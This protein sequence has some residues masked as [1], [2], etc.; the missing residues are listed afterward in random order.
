MACIPLR[1]IGCQSGSLKT[2]AATRFVQV[3]AGKSCIK[4]DDDVK[5]LIQVGSGLDCGV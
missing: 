4:G 5:L 2:L 3:V 1:I